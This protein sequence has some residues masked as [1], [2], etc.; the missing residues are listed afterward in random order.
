MPD[1]SPFDNRRKINLL[2]F[3]HKKIAVKLCK[4]DNYSLQNKQL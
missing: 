4:F 2:F 3:K 1:E